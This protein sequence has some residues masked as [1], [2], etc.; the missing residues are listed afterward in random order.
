MN[1]WKQLNPVKNINI[2]G[3]KMIFNGIKG[4]VKLAEPLKR[5][6]TF[7]IGGR[8]RFFIEPRDTADLKLLLILRKRYKIPLLVIGGGSNI[9][10]GDRGMDCAVIRL[11]S[12]YFKKISFQDNR[13]EA[14]AGN[15]LQRLISCA[16]KQGLSGLEFLAGI[17]GTLGGALAMNAGAWER[18][19]ADL[20]EKV[21]V[22]DYNGKVKAFTKKY[23]Q[24]G[25]RQSN[26]AK[27]IIL[28]A[29]LKLDRREKKEIT[30]Q[31]D[32]YISQRK[33]TQELS[34][35][36]AGCIF[37]NPEGYSA[38]RLIDLCGLKG[39]RI[40]RAYISPRHANFILH[41]GKACAK[42]VLKLMGLAKRQV[43]DKFNLRL[44]PEIKIWK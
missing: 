29:R 42:D 32:R 24:F 6:T 34:G 8:V 28:K 20:V 43:K 15:F 36:S 39:K 40:G 4:K 41:K 38:G 16:Q 5:H 18:N 3:P 23:L 37:K 44:E 31:I 30:R 2:I 14:G 27:Y 33:N 13:L 26:L 17:P 22:M 12:P 11:S 35:Y 21:T 1:W 7:K 10:A 25:Y 9:L 19:I